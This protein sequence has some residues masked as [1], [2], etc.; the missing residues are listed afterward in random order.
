MRTIELLD[1]FEILLFADESE[2]VI[3]DLR[4]AERRRDG[5]TWYTPVGHFSACYDLAEPEQP[6]RWRVEA[7]F[8]SD[9]VWNAVTGSVHVDPG[10]SGD[11]PHFPEELPEELANVL[12]R[13]TVCT[14]P[15]LLNVWLGWNTHY[16]ALGQ[17]SDED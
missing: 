14:K 2:G 3:G 16:V 1:T 10:A 12:V 6:A 13:E 15:L 8:R 17:V 11:L 5:S 9:I 4:H 7:F